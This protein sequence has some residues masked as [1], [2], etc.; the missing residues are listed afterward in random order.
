MKRTGAISALWLFL[1]LACFSFSQSDD[2]AWYTEGDFAPKIRIR[3]IVSNPL[4]Y[5]V[6]DS[7]VIVPRGV[8]PIGGFYEPDVW[9]VDPRLPSQPVPTREEA[10]RVG[11][12]ITFEETNG[13]HLPCQVDDLDKDGVWDEIFFM[14]DFKANEKKTFFVY[15]GEDERG[16]FEH[17]THAEIGSYGRHLMPWWE[18][19][20]MG[21][22]LWYPTDVDLYGKR[23]PMLV[24]NHEN[25]LNLSGYTA[26]SEF[27]N[28]IM[29]VEDTFG[30]GGICLFEDPSQPGRASRPRFGPY[31]KKGQI[32]D[33]RYAYD[34]VVNGPLRSLIRVHI[35]NWRSGKGTYEVEQ[36]YSAYK[37]KAY[38]TARVRFLRWSPENA[39]VEFGCGIR[40]LPREV[41]LIKENGIIMSLAK[42][43][44]IF[45]PDVQKKY[46]T[47]LLVKNLGT[48]LVV[49][50]KYKPRYQFIPEFAGN[51]AFSMPKTADLI[52]EYLIA[53]G[54]SEGEVDKTPEEFKA[55]VRRMAAENENPAQILEAKLEKRQN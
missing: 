49:K 26:G 1:G 2:H 40:K 6:K 19:K 53:A 25:T 42:D 7:P 39:D 43:V 13:H 28:D 12:G 34:V 14:S 47:R 54:W 23:K 22:K 8:M 21:W 55:H 20:V 5:D 38:S 37:N 44:D 17:E 11:S 15:I 41:E 27:G 24:A 31:Q 33:T 10:I 4:A 18:S 9:V 45:D 46:A 29:T 50:N 16:M 48:A 3:I 32:E 35:M 30:A 36:M 52:F 51:H